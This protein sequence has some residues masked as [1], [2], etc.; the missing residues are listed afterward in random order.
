MRGIYI[1]SKAHQSFGMLKDG[2]AIY[3]TFSDLL[4]GTLL[5]IDKR[6]L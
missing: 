1:S 6:R 5:K 3:I 4:P 2:N